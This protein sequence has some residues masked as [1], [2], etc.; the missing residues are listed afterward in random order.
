M[1]EYC[2]SILNLNLDRKR[3]NITDELVEKRYLEALDRWDKQGI[4]FFKSEVKLQE[5]KEILKYAYERVKTKEDREEYDKLIY[6]QKRYE[7]I[8]NPKDRRK[9]STKPNLNKGK[10]TD[11]NKKMQSKSTKEMV[12]QI[13]RQAEKDYPIPTPE[14]LEER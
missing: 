9:K 7:Q 13:K 10:I 6:M 4:K 14:E 5:Y 3:G 1:I 12:E 8:I 2:Y 11:L